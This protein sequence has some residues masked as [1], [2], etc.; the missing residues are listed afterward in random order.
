M[1]KLIDGSWVTDETLIAAETKQYEQAGGRFQRGRAGFRNWV[2]ADGSAGPTGE[3]GYRAEAGRYHL[4]AALNC[5]WAHRT[6]IYRQLKGLTGLISL[7]L[8]AP[9]RTE[10]GWVFEAGSQQFCEPLYDL[11]ALHQLYTRADK[12]FT[13]R[14]TVP[15]L[16]DKQTE[17]IVS[18]ESADIIRMFNGAFNALTGDQQD[19]CPLDQLAE[20]D[21]LNEYIFSHINNG[22]YQAGFARSQEAY[23]EAVTKVFAALDSLEGRLSDRAFLL[24]ETPLEP[25]W[26]LL[27]TLARFDVGYYSAFKCN[28]RALRDYPR[29]SAYF[30]R[31]YQHPGIAETIHFDIYRAGY[32]SRSP[33]RNPHGIV[34]V[35]PD[36]ALLGLR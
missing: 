3:G 33:L 34:P 17:S 16:W 7:S 5:P 15:V 20:I 31:L 22:V 14:V 6:L 35:G 27:P 26:R 13:G 21:A 4:F 23:G 24:G 9:L 19:F 8:A 25:D 32:H 28:L 12:N 29:L 10:Q 2:S 30:R 1:G 18:N 36:P 11:S